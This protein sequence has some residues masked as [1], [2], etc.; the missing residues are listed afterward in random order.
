MVFSGGGFGCCVLSA[1]VGG[2]FNFFLV[3]ISRSDV[4]SLLSAV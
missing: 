2:D 4:E 3:F 1:G